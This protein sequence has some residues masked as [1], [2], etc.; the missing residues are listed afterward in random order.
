MPK[1]DTTFSEKGRD[2][3]Q[4]AN[5]STGSTSSTEKF[6]APPFEPT[7]PLQ[8]QESLHIDD[9]ACALVLTADDGIAVA[10]RFTI[11][12][13]RNGQAGLKKQVAQPK[14]GRRFDDGQVDPG[15][16]LLLGT[17]SE[18]PSDA[19]RLMRMERDGSVTTID[20]D[21]TLSS[22]IDWSPDGRLL[23]NVDTLT[24]QIFVRDYEPE[25]G[26]YGLRRRFVHLRVGLP[27]GMCV[28]A[29][30]YLW[31]A[32]WGAGAIARL[33]PTGEIVDRLRLPTPHLSSMAFAG[34]E[35]ETLVITTAREDL[36]E[37]ELRANPLS[38]QIF[39]W[40]PPVPGNP[41]IRWDSSAPHLSPDSASD[42]HRIPVRGRGA[43]RATL[44]ISQIS[45][46]RT[47]SRPTS[48][49][50]SPTLAHSSTAYRLTTST[51]SCVS[52]A[53]GR[54]EP[55]TPISPPR[56]SCPCSP[57]R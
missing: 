31:V 4:C 44:G 3:I 36:T 39:T 32:L 18:S 11:H 19:E 22:G 38:G 52:S 42:L 57:C 34:S 17:L 49:C 33:S 10:G 43:L 16:R 23:Y 9:T 41:R 26:E 7:E 28:D 1:P 25:S 54:S 5:A 29:E 8:Y 21:L 2:G 50:G 12:V 24:S 14:V 51:H 35:L 46:S 27:D 6:T 53:V 13:L 20:D 56:S 15:G 45:A 47:A 37:S 30:G 40:R 55:T 48:V